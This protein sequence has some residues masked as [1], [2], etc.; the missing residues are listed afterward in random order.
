MGGALE[1]IEH[2]ST[3]HHFFKNS[4]DSRLTYVSGSAKAA[5]TSATFPCPHRKP[6]ELWKS[7][8]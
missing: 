5:P 2:L 8:N 4:K 3:P 1:T 7:Q 6:S